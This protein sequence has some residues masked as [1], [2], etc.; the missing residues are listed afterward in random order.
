M[1][2]WFR[3]TFTFPT[4][5]C[6]LIWQKIRALF[7]CRKETNDDRLP[8]DNVGKHGQRDKTFYLRTCRDSQCKHAKD[9]HPS[10]FYYFFFSFRIPHAPACTSFALSHLFFLDASQHSHIRSSPQSLLLT[11]PCLFQA[12]IGCRKRSGQLVVSSAKKAQA[13]LLRSRTNLAHN[14]AMKKQ[15]LQW[16]LHSQSFDPVVMLYH[17]KKV[18]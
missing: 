18:L 1:H 12:I 7:Q 4:C 15:T 2:D 11:E 13:C 17:Y 6:M 8:P 10:Y 3:Q 5:P 9:F 16:T 14:T